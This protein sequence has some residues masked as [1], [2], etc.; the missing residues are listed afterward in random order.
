MWN[1]FR[2]I[3]KHHLLLT[4]IVVETIALSMI[5]K[6]SPLKNTYIIRSVETVK[7]GMKS[8][9]ASVENYILLR[10]RNREIS[11]NNLDL[12]AENIE[13]K[14]LL[15]LYENDIQ[16]KNPSVAKYEYVHAHVIDNVLNRK[17]NTLMLDV[18]ENHGV[19]RDMGV[20]SSDGIV[21]IVDRTSS[22]FCTVI[23]LLNPAKEISA[24]HGKSG[25]Y[26]PLVWDGAD[27]RYTDL[28]DIPSHIAIEQGDSI[29]TSGYSMI[30]PEGIFIGTVENYS[31]KNAGYKIKVKLNNNFKS[32]YNVYVIKTFYKQ[33][34]DSLNN[35]KQK[36]LNKK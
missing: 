12:I 10:S 28:I 6:S 32:L 22:N 21:G 8:I 27:I 34:F 16:V 35:S 14:Y 13:L 23:S 26:G 2:F 25:I 1:L 30:F 9:V 31:V 24:K 4:F 17:H 18:G 15:S 20:I 5:F 3:G 33:E 7:G 11:Q 36:S 19:Y 29:V